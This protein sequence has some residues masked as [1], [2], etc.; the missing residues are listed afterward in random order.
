MSTGR[1]C[2]ASRRV[3][4]HCLLDMGT[5]FDDFTARAYAY[6]TDGV[7]AQAQA[8]RAV[9]R[10]AM[11]A[12]GLTVY[13]GEW[14]HFDGPG[15]FVHRPRFS[16]PRFTEAAN[17]RDEPMIER[18]LSFGSVA[19]AY[20]R[21]RLGYPD[22]LVDSVVAYSGRP[23][24]TALEIGAG[25]G[26]A[27]RVFAARGIAVT[28]TEPDRAMLAE[29]RKRVPATVITVPASFEDLP[30]GPAGRDAGRPRSLRLDRRAV[31]RG[32]C[33]RG[34][35]HPGGPIPSSSPV[36]TFRRRMD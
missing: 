11:D 17:S 21:F 10:P 22:Q 27:T 1:H 18:A 32:R 2:A 12:G 24:R 8:N 31:A 19:A 25:T 4:G 28:A 13:S 29:L 20:E 34:E 36:M 23:V 30:L 14:W 16:G 15:S 35:R 5:G 7:S 6:A 26:K 3:Q 33:W 9:L